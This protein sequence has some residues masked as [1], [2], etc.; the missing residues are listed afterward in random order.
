MTMKPCARNYYLSIAFAVILT[1]VFIGIVIS[2]EQP[3]ILAQ[4]KEARGA[5]LDTPINL[6]GVILD[7]NGT[8]VTGAT[9]SLHDRLS[10]PPRT[11]L[12]PW[13]ISPG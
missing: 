13:K 10:R 4:E 1:L 9:V 6:H 7:A 11:D 8:P 3:D 5:L 2:L 12:F